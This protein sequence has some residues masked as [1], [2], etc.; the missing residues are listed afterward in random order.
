MHVCGRERA[1]KNILCPI[2]LGLSPLVLDKL[3]PDAVVAEALEAGGWG[4]LEI[5]LRK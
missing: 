1:Q 5:R 4:P 2:S 3:L